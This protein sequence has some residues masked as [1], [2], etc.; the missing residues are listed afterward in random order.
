MAVQSA[1]EAYQ[2]VLEQSQ[3]VIDLEKTNQLMRWDSDVMMPPGG[4]PARS[5]QR[6]T[7]SA[8]RHRYL[9]DDRLG[10]ALNVLDDADLDDGQEAI[11]REVRREYTTASRIPD[12]L[13]DEISAINSRAHESWKE[14]REAN[15]WSAFGPLVAEH[16]EVKKQWSNHVDPDG[17]PYEVIWS[18]RTGYLGQPHI[19]LE[20]VDRIFDTLRE[21]LVPLIED[22]HESGTD[23]A[24]DALSS[25]SGEFDT[26]TQ[27]ELNR[28]ALDAVGLDWDRTRFDIAPHPFSFGNPYDVRMTTRYD[29]TD[30][31]EALTGTLHE[32]GHTAYAHGLSQEQ[33]GTPLGEPRGIG[34]HESQSRFFENHVGRTQAF[35]EHFMPTVRE[36]YPQLEDVTAREAY[37]AVNQVFKDN[38]IRVEADELTYHMHIILRTEI[39][40]DLFHNRITADEIPEL[41]N[42]KMEDY[43]G[44][45]PSTDN[46]GCLQDPHWSRSLPGFI[47]YTIGSVLAAQLDAAMREELN[48]D[49]DELIRD[50]ELG[51]IREWLTENV[52]SH[53]QFFRADELVRE[54]TGEDLTADYFVEY[55]NEK[56][57]DLYDLD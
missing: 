35:W 11:V 9:T 20:T 29:E 23:L 56:Y 12:D 47:G 38:F 45:R 48:E 10:E 31:T 7:L 55:V 2:I 19:S 40:R 41:W 24:T 54:A 13:N 44:I 15:D 51:P 50:C 37:E 43:L 26:A 28:A 22:I 33:Y 27:K 6:T 30:L 36:H 14:A 17:D 49:V 39:E 21:E 52:H 4:A 18:Q 57:R 5:S 8:A 34:I 53:G 3:R 25:E 32:F 16:F 1:E 42:D 46:E